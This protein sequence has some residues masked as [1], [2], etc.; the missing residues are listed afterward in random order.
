MS[1]NDEPVQYFVQ[2][3]EAECRRLLE[4]APVGRVAWESDEG[5]MVLPVNFAYE[6]DSIVFHTAPETGLAA[7]TQPTAVAFQVDDI[8]AEHRLG[9]SVLVRGITRADS[10]HPPHSWVPHGRTLGIEISVDWLEG[11]AVSG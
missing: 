1:A 8:D 9:W 3:D 11:R 7:L 5:V 4:Q 2:L 6:H 10:S